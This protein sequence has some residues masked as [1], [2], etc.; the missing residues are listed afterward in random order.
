MTVSR[1]VHRAIAVAIITVG[2]IIGV[3]VG[4]KINN[5]LNAKGEQQIEMGQKRNLEKN[6]FPIRDDDP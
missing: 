5:H 6:T 4:M 3:I 2:I 1:N